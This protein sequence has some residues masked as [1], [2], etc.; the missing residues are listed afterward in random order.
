MSVM[1]ITMV[2]VII[3]VVIVLMLFVPIISIL[4]LFSPSYVMFLVPF[5][6]VFDEGWTIWAISTK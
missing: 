5:V 6:V 3:V 2:M 4:Y 1:L